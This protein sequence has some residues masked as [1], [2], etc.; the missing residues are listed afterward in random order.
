VPEGHT[1]LRLADRHR[2]LF[3]G[4]PVLVESPQGRFAD[5]AKLLSG[6]VL[7]ETEAYGKHLLHHYDHGRTVH[8]HLGLYGKFA[9][10]SGSAPAPVGQVRLRMRNELSWLELRG[11]TACEILDELQV[12]ALLDRLGPDPLRAAADPDLAFARIRT[13]PTPLMALL[14]NQEIVAGTGL[15]FVTEALYRAGLRPTTPGRKLTRKRWE[16]IWVDLCELMAYAV[17]TGRIDTVRDEHTPEA[18]G[19]PPRVDDHGGEVYV[20]RRRGQPCYV[21]GSVVRTEVLAGRNL[22]W[23]P[24]CQPKFRSRAR[25]A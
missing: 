14:L 25:S 8:I 6:T 21:C 16:A 17:R 23:C 5:G 12:S 18:M 13:S 15:I 4:Y 1:I 22:F 11:P 10:G 19:R 7:R 9:D 3:G 24:R 20:Y 2:Q